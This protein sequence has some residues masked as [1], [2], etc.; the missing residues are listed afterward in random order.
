MARKEAPVVIAYDGSE[1][2]RAALREAA[3]LFPGRPAVIVTVWEPALATMA[4][5]PPDALSMSMMPDPATV[6][7]VDRVQREHASDVVAEGAE[8]ANSLGLA[9]EPQAVPDERDV[10]ETV[11][12]IARQRDAGVVVVGSHGISGLRSRLLGSVAR[13]LI[14]HS[15]RPVLVIRGVDKG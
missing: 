12:E 6:E 5:G 10:A 13:K 15:N 8:L 1:V 14:E 4:V 7:A 2:S 9:A 11:I 3:A